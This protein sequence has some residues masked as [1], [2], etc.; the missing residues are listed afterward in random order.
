MQP[1]EGR[2]L[3]DE[4][5]AHLL[6]LSVVNY[7]ARTRESVVL[8]DAQTDELFGTDAFI[9][10]DVA[11]SILCTPIVH[12]NRLVGVLY[13]QNDLVPGAFTEDRL[14]VLTL[15][16]A[17]AAVSLEAARAYARVRKSENQLQS[18][19]DN[20]TT[21]IY[22]KDSQGRYMMV[23][24]Q[25]AKLAGRPV[26]QIIGA[27]DF[28]ILP[29]EM[30]TRMHQHDAQVFANGQ[31]YNWE[32]T[33]ATEGTK[34]TYLSVKFPLYDDEGT[35]YAIGGVSTD[36]TERKRAEQVLADY[37]RA[38]EEQVA[39]RT[40]ELRDKN[41]QLQSTL[42]QLQ[43]AQER[44]VLQQNLAYLGTL[45]AGIAHEIQNPLNFVINFAQISTMLAED[46]KTQIEEQKSSIDETAHEYLAE[47]IGDLEQNSAKINQHGQRID[48]IVKSM[49]L[50]SR[51]I[52]PTAAPT[53][54]NA[55]LDESIDLVYHALRADNLDLNIQF[56]KKYDSAL[57]QEKISVVAQD[58]SRV[59]SNII[60][61]AVYAAQKAK[62]ETR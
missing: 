39:Q 6:P 62:R 4:D 17:Q 47:I 53:S 3:T 18:I 59:F 14:R 2:A 31:P 16:A 46:L 43:D 42:D 15:L 7:V 60:G 5:A 29:S 34:R 22:M 51:G 52:S 11:R 28:E 26:E 38:L 45:T 30:A 44:M 56:E 48:S 36:I 27:S 57:N 1:L 9:V 21:I 49:L 23:N 25:F 50:H 24:T 55:L 40:V 35:A 13:L 37:S 54:I 12:Q 10:Q 61:N 33:I 32:E 19:L 41:Q 20:A 58:L 8:I